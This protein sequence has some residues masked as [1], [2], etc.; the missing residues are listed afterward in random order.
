MN[1]F[2]V[3]GGATMKL[4]FKAILCIFLALI[5]MNSSFLYALAEFIYYRGKEY[6]SSY[7]GTVFRV[8]ESWE[9]SEFSNEG[10]EWVEFCAKDENGNNS[11]IFYKKYDSF[12]SLFLAEGKILSNSVLSNEKIIYDKVVYFQTANKPL[13]VNNTGYDVFCYIIQSKDFIHAFFI[14]INIS[15]ETLKQFEK[16]IGTVEFSDSY[17]EISDT[18]KS[19]AFADFSKDE[20]IS[21]GEVHEREANT[22]FL[23]IAFVT[24]I[25]VL[26]FLVVVLVVFLLK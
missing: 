20:K 1:N 3:L 18:E 4:T 11:N 23:S 6:E 8:P 16:F 21:N 10:Q 12:N 7:F 15:D 9:V 13:M 2:W 5:F 26:V 14:E 19:D 24:I 25:I 22:V 17:V